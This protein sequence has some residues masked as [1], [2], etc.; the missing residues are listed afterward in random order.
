MPQHDM[1]LAN[2]AGAAFR[3]DLNDALAAL[4]SQNSGATEPAT[5]YAYMFWADTTNGR[6]KQRNAANNAWLDRGPLAG[7]FGTFTE[8]VKFDKSAN[9]ASGA[10]VNLGTATGNT[11]TVTHSAGTTA[12]TSLGGASLQA[13]TEIETIFSISG[14]TL[15]ITHHATNL[16]LAGGANITLAN[17]DTIRWKKMH[18]SNAEWKMVGGVRANGEAWIVNSIPAGTVTWFAANSAPTGFLKANGAAVSRTTYSALFAVIGTTF[19]AGDG[20]TTF[21]LPDLRGEF[22][23]GWD[24]ARG[25]DSGRSF[26]SAQS[27]AAK[28]GTANYI[29]TST[30][31]TGLTLQTAATAYWATTTANGAETRPRNVALL[32]CI[33]F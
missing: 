15:T 33:K 17:G 28:I 14:G 13:G 19:G 2:Q 6:L 4:V 16:Y 24:D 23:R 21:N 26:G 5:M 20:S 9:I 32:A 10:T 18:D 11:V 8:L 31:G 22:V 27:G 29:W 25:V 7:I 30:S 3:A 12:I 1:I